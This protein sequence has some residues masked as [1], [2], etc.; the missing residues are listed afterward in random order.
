MSMLTKFKLIKGSAAWANPR[1]PE[2]KF[3]NNKTFREIGVANPTF[4]STY[5]AYADTSAVFFVLNF[6][7]QNRCAAAHDEALARL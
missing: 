3:P 5:L 1:F 4:S 7:S 2:V 6:S